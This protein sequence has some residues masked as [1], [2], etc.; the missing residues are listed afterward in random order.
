MD[1]S[2]L[3]A[4]GACS[5][6]V[7]W[8]ESQVDD[9]SAWAACER[10]DWM[11]WLLSHK[12]GGPWGEGRKALVLT[13]C[14]CAR[15]SLRYTKDPRA[16]KCVEVVEAWT[17][18]EATVE[19]VRAARRA[20]AYAADAADAAAYAAIAAAD[21]AADAAAAYAADAGAGAAADAA[22][23]AAAAYAAVAAKHR[24]VLR[25]CADIVRKHYPVA[26]VL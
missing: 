14:E 1:V 24:E 16:L 11:L 26:P 18:G 2:K 15:L 7:E 22:A 9:A 25:S 3:K 6:G 12:T 19:E 5:E 13:A 10:G 21:A 4:L 23:D 8:A 20:A 17:R